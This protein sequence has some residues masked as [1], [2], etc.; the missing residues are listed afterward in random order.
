[1]E[2]ERIQRRTSNGA[3][4]SNYRNP[5]LSKSA[6]PDFQSAGAEI[7]ER[8][9]GAPISESCPDAVCSSKVRLEIFSE[10]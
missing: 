9:P 1:M 3:D 2:F 8:K 10:I 6:L 4:D 5:K 7:A